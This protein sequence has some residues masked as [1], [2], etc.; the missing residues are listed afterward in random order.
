MHILEKIVEAK[1]KRVEEAKQRVSLEKLQRQAD[2]VKRPGGR[3][4]E[5]ALR[6]TDQ[7]MRVIAELK[8]ASPSA[9][10]IRAE[11]DPL[12]IGSE[13]V[14]A[15]A[16]ALS[17]LTEQDFFQGH[18]EFLQTV[19]GHFND[20]PILRKDFI[21]D[22]Y[23]LWEAVAWG[24]DAILLI[25][26]ILDESQLKELLREAKELN[27][28]V[29]VEVH[30]EEELLTALNAEAVIIGIN[31]RDLKTFRVDIRQTE[32]LLASLP[33]KAGKIIVS[34]S[35]IKTSEDIAFL[36]GLGVDAVLVGESLMRAKSP[37]E[38]LRELI[39]HK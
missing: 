26:A 17:I 14:E 24:A 10:V 1:K 23:Q 39:C 34:E 18:P 2:D 32:R 15:G 28:A 11:I 3:G 37:G 5:E 12:A 31:N 25:V 16:D 29:L 7:R 38:A 6:R 20:I 21:F 22:R 35:G 36:R 8:K 9:G 33:A 4:F 30:T 19:R 27:L 13:L